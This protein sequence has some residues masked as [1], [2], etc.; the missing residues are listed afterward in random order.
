MP[1][2]FTWSRWR[3]IRNATWLRIARPGYPG[4]RSLGI[5]W[6]RNIDRLRFRRQGIRR[7]D[8]PIRPPEH[9][10][11]KSQCLTARTASFTLSAACFSSPT[12][13]SA[14]PSASRRRFFVAP[15][16][17]FFSWLFMCPLFLILLVTLIGCPRPSRCPAT[18]RYPD[19]T[20]PKPQTFDLARVRVGT[21]KWQLSR[22]DRRTP[23][24]GRKQRRTRIATRVSP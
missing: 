4:R 20:N 13:R 3:R 11:H 10:I 15:P 5:N 16:E 8:L 14:D 23:R 21:S 12:A 7:G 18:F 22:R 6:W 2:A 9:R 24:T 1:L 19:S 17:A